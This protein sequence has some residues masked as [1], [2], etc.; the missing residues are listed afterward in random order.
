MGLKQLHLNLIIS[1]QASYG[2]FQ[3]SPYIKMVLFQSYTSCFVFFPDF[4]PQEI[5]VCRV[6]MKQ[7]SYFDFQGYCWKLCSCTKIF[8]LNFELNPSVF[9]FFTLKRSVCGYF[10]NILRLRVS[11]LQES[12]QVLNFPTYHPSIPFKSLTRP[13]NSCPSLSVQFLSS[14]TKL[15]YY[16]PQAIPPS[17]IMPLFLSQ[18]NVST[19][20][21]VLHLDPRKKE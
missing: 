11:L 6:F 19:I 13:L 17:K 5:T 21:R 20:K 12:I 9:F 18:F 4:F 1:I 3:T 15:I 7:I 8:A 2:H 16:S 10:F 14:I